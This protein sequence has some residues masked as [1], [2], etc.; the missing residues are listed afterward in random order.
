VAGTLILTTGGVAI[1]S[2]AEPRSETE[3][4]ATCSEAATGGSATCSA[5]C[6]APAAEPVVVDLTNIL[7]S[8]A[9]KP[10]VQLNTRGY[11]YNAPRGLPP[12]QPKTPQPAATKP[13]Q[14]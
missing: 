2:K 4:A 7:E 12:P 14:E 11:N 10:A 3:A 5:T 1:E 9:G 13:E 8:S 6:Q